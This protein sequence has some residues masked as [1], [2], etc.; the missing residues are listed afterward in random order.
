M[1]AAA[2]LFRRLAARAALEVK[3]DPSC[4]T[5]IRVTV[6]RARFLLRDPQVWEGS[7]HGGQLRREHQTWVVPLDEVL[8][9]MEQG[10]TYRFQDR[11]QPVRPLSFHLK[12]PRIPMAAS[13]LRFPSRA[14]L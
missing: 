11:L 5:T 7:F 1:G 2:Y 3:R 4:T 12:S 10:K 6:K 8:P 9:H 13:R 14:R